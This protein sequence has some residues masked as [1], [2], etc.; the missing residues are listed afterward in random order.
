VFE[1]LTSTRGTQ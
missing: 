1:K